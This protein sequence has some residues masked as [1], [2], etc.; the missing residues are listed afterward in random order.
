MR[1]ANGKGDLEA[2]DVALRQLDLV[3]ANLKR[4]LELGRTESLRRESCDL[5]ALLDETVALLQP[6]CKHAGTALR[7]Q[8]PASA[9]PLTGD[10]VQL[11]H[12]FLNVLSN[13]VEAA[14]PGGWVDVGMA[15]DG[16]TGVVIEV[17]D[18]GPGPPTEIAARL[19]QPFVTGK[20]EGIGLG[21]AVARQV[22]EA[23]GGRIAWCRDNDAT[24]FRIELP[25][26][27]EPQAESERRL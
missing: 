10:T 9:H 23:H 15:R 6:Q 21:L 17:R 19:F 2:L 25:T 3:E 7:W 24:C 14:G 1:A 22:A 16:T 12:L 26:K 8:P 5:R 27:V 18:S 13:A 4:F 20:R 11:G